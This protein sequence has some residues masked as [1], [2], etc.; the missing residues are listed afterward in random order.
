VS[1]VGEAKSF[2]GERESLAWTRPCP[3]RAVHPARE[4]KR[5]GP[6]ADP[7][8]EMALAEVF[9]VVGTDFLDRSLIDFAFRY[10]AFAHEILQPCDAIR[11][12][13]IIVNPH[14]LCSGATIRR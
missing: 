11:F 2:T 3:H 12:D 5:V 8:E 7:G 13:L 6:T 14:T 10:V 1:G 4:L 9:E